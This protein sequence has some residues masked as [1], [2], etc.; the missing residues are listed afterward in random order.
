MFMYFSGQC[1]GKESMRMR[2]RAVFQDQ[3]RAWFDVSQSRLPFLV[4][5]ARTC[6]CLDVVVIRQRSIAHRV[7]DIS[8]E[9][10]MIVHELNRKLTNS[11]IESSL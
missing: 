3:R 6:A 8:S 10:S 2:A 7:M 4:T 9:R 1:K 5:R 11:G